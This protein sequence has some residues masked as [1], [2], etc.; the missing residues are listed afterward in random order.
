MDAFFVEV[1]RLRRPELRGRPVV[2]GGSG[3]RSV[4]A[5][6]SYE[7]RRFGVRS[8]MPSLEARRRCPEL[9]FVAPDHGAYGAAS[10]GVFEV[11]RS[12]TPLVQSLSVDEAFLDVG[13]LRLHHDSP[14]AVAAAIRAELRRVVDL[15]ASVGIAATPFVAKLASRRAKPDGL[16][17]VPIA[18]TSIRVHFPK[19]SQRSL[20][21]HP[22]TPQVPGGIDLAAGL[23]IDRIE[24]TAFA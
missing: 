18:Q 7:A 5:A 12:F 1:E 23:L 20:E 3:R 13:G 15:P 17:H 11:L 24:F 19:Q 22:L 14:V 2:V 10:E 21:V 9:V 6:A 16:R 4:V 8:A